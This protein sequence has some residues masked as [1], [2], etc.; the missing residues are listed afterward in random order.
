V[1][2]LHFTRLYFYTFTFLL[3]G[4]TLTFEHTHLINQGKTQTFLNQPELR[5]WLE[6]RGS[7]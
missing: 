5:F 3:L 7:D 2:L 4:V 6:W 1:A